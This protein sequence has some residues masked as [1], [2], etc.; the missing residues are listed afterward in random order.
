MRGHWLFVGLAL[1]SCTPVSQGVQIGEGGDCVS[2]GST[3]ELQSRDGSPAGGVVEWW[4]DG[5]RRYIRHCVGECQSDV[6]FAEGPAMVVAYVGGE[7]QT[8]EIDMEVVETTPV[9]EAC[10]L[11][12]SFGVQVLRF[13]EATPMSEACPD[14][15][16]R[17]TAEGTIVGTV[18]GERVD[19]SLTRDDDSYGTATQW[20]CEA[21]VVSLSY[22]TFSDETKEPVELLSL[23]ASLAPDGSLVTLPWVSLQFGPNDEY[24]YAWDTPP[25]GAMEVAPLTVDITV[26]DYRVRGNLEGT[27]LGGLDG[28]IPVDLAFDTLPTTGAEI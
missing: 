28:G 5:E 12:D 3:V 23:I 2:V 18:N 21:P 14:A 10:V 26:E 8:I 27:L 17:E 15:P 9:D 19:L 4:Q 25:H 7:Q 6:L 13:D 22:A 1:G 16:E 24:A 11:A 20:G